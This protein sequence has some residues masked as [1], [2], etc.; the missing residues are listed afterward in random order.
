MKELSSSEISMFHSKVVTARCSAKNCPVEIPVVKNPWKI[1]VKELS[2]VN[3]SLLKIN[4][5]LDVFEVRQQVGQLYCRTV[6]IRTASV[7]FDFDHVLSGSFRK[8]WA[9]LK[10]ALVEKTFD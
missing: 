6:F 10:I 9:H 5:F 8:W 2:L 1:P 4:A 3:L 7:Y